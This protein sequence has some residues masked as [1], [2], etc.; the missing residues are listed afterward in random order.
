MTPAQQKSASG[1]PQQWQLWPNQNRIWW[2]DTMRSANKFKL[3]MSLVTSILLYGRETW[4]L[5]ADSKEDP[6]FRNQ[7]PE[8]TP[9]LANRLGAQDHRLGAE[10]GHLPCG[11]TGTSFGNC[12]ETEICMVPACQTPRQSLQNHPSGHLGGW[13]T[14]WSAIDNTKEWISLP[15]TELLTRASCRK[16]LKTISTNRP[17]A[18]PPPP[19][20]QSVN[21]LT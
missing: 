18:P 17:Y 9:H 5:L 12:Q 4:T 3:Y 20:T 1:L 19:P 8:K 15:L 16:A 7:V 10:Q 21:G 6:G 14:P 11:S 13:A 2:C